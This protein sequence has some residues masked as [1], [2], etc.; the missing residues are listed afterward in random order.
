MYNIYTKYL[1]TI[2]FQSRFKYTKI[3]IHFPTL[4]LFYDKD[5]DDPRSG[6][7]PSVPTG[8]ISPHHLLSQQIMTGFRTCVVYLINSML[9]RDS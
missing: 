6:K 9:T 2:H 1:S 5:G 8:T 7:C 3:K 4:S